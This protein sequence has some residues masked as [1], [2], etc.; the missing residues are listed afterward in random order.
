MDHTEDLKTMS[1]AIVDKA[2]ESCSS[3]KSCIVLKRTGMNIL[4]KPKRD[5]WWKEETTKL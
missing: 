2:L 5:F 1:K 3:I 4:M